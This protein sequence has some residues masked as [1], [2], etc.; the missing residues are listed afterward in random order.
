MVSRRNT[1]PR[2]YVFPFDDYKKQ[3]RTDQLNTTSIWADPPWRHWSLA[4]HH[5][6]YSS[7]SKAVQ[8]CRVCQNG[9]VTAP[10]WNRF[11]TGDLKTVFS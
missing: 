3:L 2:E 4:A 1:Q 8:F 5:H 11:K 9:N 10:K 7:E 6:F